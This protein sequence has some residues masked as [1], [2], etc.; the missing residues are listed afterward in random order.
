MADLPLEFGAHGGALVGSC[1]SGVFSLACNSSTAHA[2]ICRDSRRKDSMST[3]LRVLDFRALWVLGFF[4]EGYCVTL[5]GS[6]ADDV[7]FSALV[8][9]L[10]VKGPSSISQDRRLRGGQVAVNGF[11][12]VPAYFL[13][14]YVHPVKLPSYCQG[15]QSSVACMQVM[16]GWPTLQR[17]LSSVFESSAMRLK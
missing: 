7:F 8:G 14:L 9:V 17:G 2:S 5:S 6:C 10:S 11:A 15:A 12:S 13:T 4:R 16:R 1:V 3:P